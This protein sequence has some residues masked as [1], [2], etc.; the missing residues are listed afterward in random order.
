MP[1]SEKVHDVL[2]M[3]MCSCFASSLLQAHGVIPSALDYWPVVVWFD[4]W[5]NL[6]GFRF[7]PIGYQSWKVHF[8]KNLK[9]KKMTEIFQNTSGAF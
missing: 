4:Q 5:A 1:F 8:S 9:K 6:F 7:F 2:L 3:E